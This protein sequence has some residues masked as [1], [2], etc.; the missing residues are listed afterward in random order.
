MGSYVQLGP[1]RTYYEED[2]SGEPLV[3]LHPGLA[4]S[5]A[6]EVTLP[7]LS[8]ASG[9]SG[10]TGAVTAAL[11]MSTARS[12]TTRWR[13]TPLSSSSRWSAVQASAA[14]PRPLPGHVLPSPTL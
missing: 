6:F 12:A 3:F 4:D 8:I 2:G 14:R 5:R 11:P 10:P 1:V 7:D 9:S 13:R